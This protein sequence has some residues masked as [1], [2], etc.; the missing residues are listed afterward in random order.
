MKK[1]R[2]RQLNA[3]STSN[4]SNGGAGKD[5][6]DGDDELID[7]MVKLESRASKELGINEADVAV[8][9]QSDIPSKADVHHSLDENQSK[10]NDIVEKDVR[11]DD[12]NK[13]DV[14]TNNDVTMHEITNN[15]DVTVG[16]DL[17]V[18]NVDDVN[19][20]NVDDVSRN[21]EM[22]VV[23]R[24][25]ENNDISHVCGGHEVAIP[26]DKAV[27][28]LDMK[29]EAI[30]TLLCYLELHAKRWV[31]MLKSIRSTCTL[32]FYG[33]PAHLHY[34]AQRVPI[35]TAAVAY[36]RKRGEFKRNTSCLTF[37]VVKIVDEMGWDLEP[38][39]RELYGLQ[40]NEGLRLAGETGLSTG[41]SGIIV[42]FTDLAFHVRALGDLSGD[43]RD[44][45]SDRDFYVS[46][47]VLCSEN[48]CIGT[49]TVR[50]VLMKNRTRV[51]RNVYNTEVFS[52]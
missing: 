31:Q 24:P 23:D 19:V 41:H 27:Q 46:W 45:V 28:Q 29:E 38:V 18:A 5:W 36:A 44:E 8:I 21:S 33:G 11:H 12:I 13:N 39:R 6:F 15:D 4:G 40:W 37:P 16:D 1:K 34:V 35:V 49:Y 20:A 26:I 17:T 42:E 50:E 9:G 52:E 2:A 22:G 25:T 43:D 7:H 30:E 14:M 32:K 51:W 3:G 48:I 10:N 47:P